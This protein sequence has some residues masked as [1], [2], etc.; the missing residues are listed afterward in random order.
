MTHYRRAHIP[1][2]T[3]FF[4]VNLARRDTTLLTDRIDALRNAMR[5]VRARHPFVID[6]MVVL[7]EHL[8]AVWTLPPGDADHSVRWRL[9]KT[10]FCGRSRKANDAVKAASPKANAAFGNA[11][12]KIKGSGSFTCYSRSL[13]ASHMASVNKTRLVRCR[14]CWNNRAL[15][16]ERHDAE[17]RRQQRR[18]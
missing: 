4:T 11:G 9:I 14:R 10:W 17:S 15:S 3:Y 12:T 13:P 2:A 16:T 5:Y 1:G 6:A 8:H 18:L 7:P